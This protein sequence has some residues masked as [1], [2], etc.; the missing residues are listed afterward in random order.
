MNENSYVEL[1]IS[2]GSFVYV[3]GADFSLQNETNFTHR[4]SSFDGDATERYYFGYDAIAGTDLASQGHDSHI[5]NGTTN[6]RD[7]VFSKGESLIDPP[8]ITVL[9]CAPENESFVWYHTHPAGAMYIPYT[10]QICFD[11]DV[12]QCI[13]GPAGEARWVSPNL[14]YMERFVQIAETNKH[15]LKIVDLA[16]AGNEDGDE[17]C[18]YPVVFG[19][20]NFDPDDA[21]GQPNFDDSPNGLNTWGVFKSLIVRTT[22]IVTTTVSTGE[23]A[24]TAP[25][26]AAVHG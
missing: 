24:V 7:L 12:S 1:I 17:T 16:F 13:S 6:A 5:G 14:F 18:N 25:H 21:E 20:T 8:S 19:V 23:P 15:A 26:S 11:T 4:L 9:N 3:V 10:G 22:N 2:G